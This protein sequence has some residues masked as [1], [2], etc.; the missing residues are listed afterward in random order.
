MSRRV[1]NTRRV[2]TGEEHGE[3]NQS[4]PAE[5][6]TKDDLGRWLY[7]RTRPGTFGG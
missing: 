6:L 2:S 7:A 1:C 4:A 5:K 3:A